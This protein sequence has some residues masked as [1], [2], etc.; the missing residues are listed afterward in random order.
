[1]NKI[2]YRVR[3][4]WEKL[5]IL[6]LAHCSKRLGSLTYFYLDCF[7]TKNY[8]KL[9]SKHLSCPSSDKIEKNTIGCKGKCV[10]VLRNVEKISEVFC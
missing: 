7:D 6:K 9:L 2:F 10:N 1:M 4:T 3:S 8:Q 5:P